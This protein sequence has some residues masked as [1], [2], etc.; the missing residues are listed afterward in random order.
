MARGAPRR[1]FELANSPD[2][3]VTLEVAVDVR[4]APER[5]GRRLGKARG[6]VVVDRPGRR[7]IDVRG[8]LDPP[9]PVPRH[10]PCASGMTD[11]T[12]E[13]RRPRPHVRTVVPLETARLR[14][15]ER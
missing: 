7:G 14:V 15:P 5:W 9:V 1:C 10:I 3:G 2:R 4:A 6:P 8:E 13:S 11:R 12:G